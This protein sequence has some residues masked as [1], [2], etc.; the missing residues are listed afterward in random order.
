MIVNIL[1]VLAAWCLLP[2]LTLK[3]MISLTDNVRSGPR[4]FDRV[5]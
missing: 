4:L 5:P 2:R 3:A 1:R